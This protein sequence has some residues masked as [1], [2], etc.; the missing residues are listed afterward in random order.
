MEFY[1]LSL[2]F[3]YS[4]WG[5]CACGG[6]AQGF[7]GTSKARL[8]VHISIAVN[9]RQRYLVLLYSETQFLYLFHLQFPDL[10][11]RE[12]SISMQLYFLGY[13]FVIVWSLPSFLSF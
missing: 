12:E 9:R 11:S 2:A 13:L 5:F 6:L 8:G 4:N 10:S 1:R 7:S 3:H